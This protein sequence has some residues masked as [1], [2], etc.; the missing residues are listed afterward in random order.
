MANRS[1]ETETFAQ[2][3]NSKPSC[4]YILNEKNLRTLDIQAFTEKEGEGA[5]LL[6]PHIPCGDGAGKYLFDGCLLSC[7]RLC[8]YVHPPD[9]LLSLNRLH[10]L[11]LFELNTLLYGMTTEDV[12]LFHFRASPLITP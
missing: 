7:V 12:S 1:Y 3:P 8:D 11:A 4:V 6:Y 2:A 9:A 5:P 10:V